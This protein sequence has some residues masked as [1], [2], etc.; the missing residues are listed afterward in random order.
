VPHQD[1]HSSSFGISQEQSEFKITFACLGSRG[2]YKI[3]GKTIFSKGL[4][5]IDEDLIYG[6][7]T[8]FNFTAAHEIGHWCLHGA[9]RIEKEDPNEAIQETDDCETDF[10]GRKILRTSR[11][12]IEH[13]ANVFAGSLLMPRSTFGQAVQLVQRQM[14]VA[15][16]VGSI[17]LDSQWSSER[18]LEEILCRL[19]DIFET[20]K[21]SVLIRLKSLGILI[22]DNS[23][24]L[25][26]ISEIFARTD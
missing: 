15:R 23:R 21:Q 24:R 12:W 26:D 11:N 1:I 8:L 10:W 17:L 13:H 25:L 16:N 4:I 20:S 2:G 22:E 5:C 7:A 6:N 3:L 14:G 19:G 9:N 18:D